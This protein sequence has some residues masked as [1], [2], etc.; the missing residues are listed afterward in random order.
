METNEVKLKMDKT[1]ESLKGELSKIR[2]GRASTGLLDTI[3]VDYYGTKTALKNMATLSVPE[4]RLLTVQPWDISQIE[5]IEKAIL[6]ADLGLTPN[7][8]GKIIRIQI[9]QLSEE[10]RK[11]LV[12]LV[13]KVGEEAKVAARMV[14]RDAN[15]SLKKM[16]LSEDD[17]RKRQVDIQKITDQQIVF[18]DTLLASKEKDILNV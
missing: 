6:K 13:G 16:G 8:D 4:P 5:A 12:K 1:I 3:Q 15:E 9:P 7:N 2:T 14:R 11:E 18:I 17:V 10:R